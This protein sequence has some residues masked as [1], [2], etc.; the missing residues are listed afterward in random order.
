L[1]LG[2]KTGLFQLKDVSELLPQFSH[3]HPGF[4]P[5]PRV[6]TIPEPFQRFALALQLKT[7]IGV[8]KA[9][10]VRKKIGFS[11]V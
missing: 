3:S 8:R 2:K 6:S 1:Q 11:G 10:T 5:V 7:Q 9:K 4:S